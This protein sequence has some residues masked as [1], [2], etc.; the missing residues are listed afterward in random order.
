MKLRFDKCRKQE[1]ESDEFLKLWVMPNC[2]KAECH[3]T[4]Y[5]NIEIVCSNSIPREPFIKM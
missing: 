4:R 3:I 1:M 2:S 5:Y